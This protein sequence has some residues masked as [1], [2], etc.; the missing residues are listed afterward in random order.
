MKST[1]KLIFIGIIIALLNREENKNLREMQE[2]AEFM[3][4]LIEWGK[5]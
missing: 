1:Q 3:G 5:I 2:M 4:L